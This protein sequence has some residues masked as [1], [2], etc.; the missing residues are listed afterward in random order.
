MLK[1]GG[2][3]NTNLR[4][5]IIP[6]PTM[7][8]PALNALQRYCT[9]STAYPIQPASSHTAGIKNRIK[10]ITVLPEMES[11]VLGVVARSSASPHKIAT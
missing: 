5:A 9:G 1:Y 2:L 10:K 7:I 3:E 8:I 4:H 11:A 6:T